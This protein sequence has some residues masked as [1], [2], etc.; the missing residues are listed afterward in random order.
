MKK[1]PYLLPLLVVLH[2][3]ANAQRTEVKNVTAREYQRQF[4]RLVAQ[5][6]RPISVSANTLQVIDYQPGERPQLGYWGVFEKRPD[7][8]PWAARHA[9]SHEAYQREFNTWTRQG[10]MPTSINVAFMD[11]QTSYCVIYDK[12]PNPP[13]WVARHGIS[14]AEFARTNEDLLRQ[15]YRRTITSQCQTPAGRVMAGL[16]VK[17]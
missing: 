14:Y 12:I 11:G 8:T 6:Y 2:L 17:R 10:Y 4:D 5:G 3:S 9:L 15:G 13:A 16:W 7:T 1:L